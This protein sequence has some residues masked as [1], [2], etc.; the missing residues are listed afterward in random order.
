MDVQK[1]YLAYVLLQHSERHHVKLNRYI[2]NDYTTGDDRYPKTRKNNLHILTRYTKT[3]IP[4]NS[5]SQVNSF[6]HRS[7]DGRNPQRNDKAYW[8]D[9]S[10]TIVTKKSILIIIVKKRRRKITTMTKSPSPVKKL[11]QLLKTCIKIWIRLILPSPPYKL[12]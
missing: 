2:H 5:E 6:T 12:R 9:K 11:K 1:R 10:S 3:V 7:G 8:K 4:R